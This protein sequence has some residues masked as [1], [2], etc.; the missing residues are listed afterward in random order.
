MQSHDNAI[1]LRG[2]RRLLG[3]G[4]K[5]TTAQDVG[6]PNPTF[7]PIAN[8][9]AQLLAQH[10]SGKSGVFKQVHH[11]IAVAPTVNTTV[12][13]ICRQHFGKLHAA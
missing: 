11:P 6:R 2:R 12:C 4:I 10:I 9:S 7:L 5:V 3:R 8:R 1:Q 13:K